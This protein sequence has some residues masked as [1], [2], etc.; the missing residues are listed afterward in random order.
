V[1]LADGVAVRLRPDHQHGLFVLRHVRKDE[2][3]IAYD[4]PI[5][6]HATRYSIQIDESLH[7]DARLNQTLT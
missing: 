2:I 7:I 6:D 3:L 5:I 1:S 4:G